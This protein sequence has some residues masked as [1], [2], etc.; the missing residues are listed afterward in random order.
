MS[1]I[2]QPLRLDQARFFRA[3]AAHDQVE[4][5][6][7]SCL[8]RKATLRLSFE[9]DD[10]VLSECR[11]VEPPC[12]RLRGRWRSPHLEVSPAGRGALILAP[13]L[14]TIAQVEIPAAGL[15]SAGRKDRSPADF[16]MRSYFHAACRGEK[17][18]LEPFGA[19]DAAALRAGNLLARTYR[20]IAKASIPDPVLDSADAG[21]LILAA[22][23]LA[24][25]S[26]VS[27]L[28]ADGAA[29]YRVRA[30]QKHAAAD[31]G[32]Q[33]EQFGR[34]RGALLSLYATR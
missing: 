3:R 18:L 6:V 29:E 19:G 20:W 4:A 27:P 26:P 13:F 14:F 17:I 2:G 31:A 10:A 11:A 34:L 32:R 22:A 16:V 24:M 7:W 21:E 1:E 5:L 23:H 33:A 28:L 8:Q 25:P 15:V 12:W 9:A 30:D